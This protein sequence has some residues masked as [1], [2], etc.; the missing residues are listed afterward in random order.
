MRISRAEAVAAQARILRLNGFVPDII[1]AHTG[2]SEPL[3]LRDIF[4]QARLI[5]YCEYHYMRNGGDIGFDPEFPLESLDTLHRLRIRNAF[6]LATIDDADA[7]VTPTPWQRSTYPEA[8]R[9][10]I[11]VIHEGI[12]TDALATVRN[13][14]GQAYA[15]SWGIEADAP[16]ITYV[17]R[18]LEPQRGFHAFMRALPAIQARRPSS[19][20][21]VVGAERGGYGPPPVEGGTW[22]ER[23]LS[24]LD[25]QLDLTRLHFCGRVPYGDYAAILK[26]SDV[27]VYLTY[28][29]VLSWSA[30]EAMALGKA[31]V[32]S[33]TGPVTDVMTNGENARLV[34]FFDTG[35]LADHVVALLDNREE[36]NRLGIAAR[37]FV[38]THGLTRRVAC[39]KMVDFILS[40]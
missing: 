2:W 25:G 13:Q 24:E 6:E 4:P 28:P 30:L 16:V 20:I 23:M 34:D 27:H 10:G 31:I 17:A 40:G 36:A 1:F 38:A 21:L 37:T 26:R 35:A 3:F 29:F 5:C 19:R 7:C 32:A 33:A 22:K 15:R 12:D 9:A 14:D 8:V 18:Y 39:K 11:D